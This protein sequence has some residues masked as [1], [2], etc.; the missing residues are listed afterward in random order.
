MSS[1]QFCPVISTCLGFA[2]PIFIMPALIPIDSS[3]VC[4]LFLFLLSGVI[5]SYIPLCRHY[6]IHCER[7][8]YYKFCFTYFT[9]ITS[10]V[11]YVLYGLHILV[12]LCRNVNQYLFLHL[13]M[14]HIMPS[15]ICV[16]FLKF[17]PV[18]AFVN[19][20]SSFSSQYS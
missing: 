7:T 16:A 2:S 20:F 10:Y 9:W 6:Y 1:L 14:K 4:S 3:S 18:F 5:L 8:Q 11:L 19:S 12:V 15:K 17:H 13:W